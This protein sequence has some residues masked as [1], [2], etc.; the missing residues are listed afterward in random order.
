MGQKV[1]ACVVSVDT[2]ILLLAQVKVY[3][4]PTSS[5]GVNS[6]FLNIIYLKIFCQSDMQKVSSVLR[7]SD[8]GVRHFS[9]HL[10]FPDT[11][12]LMS[13]TSL[14]RTILEKPTQVLLPL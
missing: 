6:T 11:P 4:L 2:A 5:L 8:V 9:I 1:F 10:L 14:P 3:I 13:T 7:D 12:D